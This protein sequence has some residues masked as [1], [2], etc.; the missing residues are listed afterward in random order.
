MLDYKETVQKAT[1]IQ[2]IEEQ[3]AAEKAAEEG[4]KTNNNIP[5]W[6][7]RN[8]KNRGTKLNP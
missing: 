6:Q 7:D 2:A 1:N 4:P 3:A 5:T 8:V